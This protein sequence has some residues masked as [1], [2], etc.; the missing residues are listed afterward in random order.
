MS[1]TDQE[2]IVLYANAEQYAKANDI[3]LGQALTQQ[4]INELT[5]PMLWYVEQT[6]PQPGCAATGTL[7]CPTVTALMP[8]VYL[9]ANTSALSA[10][11]NI[12]ASDSLK[13]NFG[14]A[15]TGGSILNTG[16]ISSSGSLTVNTGTLTNEANQVNVGQI[17]SK[18]KG[19]YVDTTGTVVQPG[20]FMSA[21]DMNLN[22]E[23]LNQIGGALQ[24]LAADGTVDQA[25]TQ[26]M[27]AALEQQL[28]SGFTQ[29]TLSDHLHTDFVKEGGGLP[30]V[31]VAVIAIAASI[32]TAGAAAA[33]F[34]VVMT[35][36]SIGSV[37]I[38]ALGGMVGS[39]VSQ[40][41]SGQ[42]FNVGQILEAGAVGAITAGAFA[43]MGAS[44]QA[45][46]Q[47]GSKI[48]NGTVGLADVGNAMEVVLE[49]GV[50]TA[51]AESAIEGT[52]FGQ[53]LEGS[54]I[55]DLGAIGASAIG[56]EFNGQN[57]N[58]DTS[59]PLYI[60]SHAA[61]GC[62]LSAAQGT[63]CVGGAIG[64]A[65]SAA[66]SPDLLRAIDPTGAALTSG[67][68]A[69]MEGFATLLGGG[70]AGLAGANAQG[71]ANA[72]L[73]EVVNNTDDHP[74]TAAKNGG[75]LG[76]VGDWLKNTY[77][78][79]V[80]SIENWLGQFGG[81]VQSGAQQTSSQSPAALAA[82]GVANGVTAV[83]G[84]GGRL[85]PTAGPDLAPV[86]PGVGSGQMTP[87]AAGGT[88]P[89]ATLSSGESGGDS[90]SAAPAQGAGANSAVSQSDIDTLAANGVKFTPQNVVATGTTPNGQVVFLESGSSSAGL[91]HIIEGHAS[92]FAN[93]GVSE[94]QIP[95][96]VMQ[97]V[98]E[99]NIV[100]YQGSGTGRPIYQT[101][102]NGQPQRIAVTVGSNG[103]IVGA[104]PAGSV[105]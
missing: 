96:V 18:V 53:A 41:A 88:P 49:R 12:V 89:N 14:S 31:V 20:G 5:Q 17:W 73:N 81:L 27:L 45:L 16:T 52:N 83:S 55:S 15:A 60:G 91:Q 100:G 24:K 19:G 71:G 92:E 61:L 7:S 80:G 94:D 84:A 58:P 62:A 38:G 13:L 34:G 95:R 102:I 29:T 1:V 56:T 101:T 86:G 10:D 2:K 8:Q 65:A 40:V 3:K 105:K 47:F 54:A 63:G 51:T 46:Q 11:G 99:G 35:Q 50:V 42:G 4:Q 67:Q 43:A 57:N 21:A 22:V 75:V 82:Q 25:G 64:G 98:T 90:G 93:I 76:A 26:Q 32:I 104:N 97:A 70:L 78:D 85:P 66:L 30:M 6:V 37:L 79:P 39:A 23:T 103:F 77:G 28:G 9:P 44:T 33:A 59:N 74:E 69:A 68:Q 72:A 36:L 87:P 48:A